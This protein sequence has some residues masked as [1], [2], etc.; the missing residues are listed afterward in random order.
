MIPLLSVAFIPLAIA[1]Q[2]P[3]QPVLTIG[4][5]YDLLE[6]Y[7]LGVATWQ[8][9]TERI[10]DGTDW[11]D[12]I[13]YD[14][15][16][17][18]QVESNSIGSLV[19][20][21]NNCSYSI[22]ENGYV[23]SDKQIIPSVSWMPRIAEV[24]T[25]NYSEMTDLFNQQ[26]SVE[27]RQGEDWVKI[28]SV[29]TQTEDLPPT[30]INHLNGTQSVYPSG[31]TTIATTTQ[32][33]DIRTDNGIKETVSV[34]NGNPEWSNHKFALTQTIHTGDTITLAGNTYDVAAASGTVL[35]RN[36]IENN[37]A[38][39]FE[40]ADSLNYDMDV[41]FEQ[42]NALQVIDDNGTYK[43]ALDYSVNDATPYLSSY[44]VDPTFTS[45][46]STEF[47]TTSSGGGSGS[48]C[49]TATS[50]TGWSTFQV[51]SKASSDSSGY[52][53]N[54]YTEWDVSNIPDSVIIS[55]ATVTL[56]STPESSYT[57]NR[58][59]DVT[60]NFAT[61][62]STIS[63]ASTLESLINTS[64]ELTN[65][66][67]YCTSSG[68]KSLTLTGF[69]LPD[70]QDWYAT[71]Y[72]Y[73]TLTRD[74]NDHQTR[75]SNAILEVVYTLPT[76]PSAPANLSAVSGIPIALDWDASTDLGGAAT[77]DM[78]Y[79]VERSD[80]EFAE[81]PLPINA[82]S[83]TG[84]NMSTNVLLYHLDATTTAQGARDSTYDATNT[85]VTLDTS[86]QKLGSGAYD[87]DSTSGHSDTSTA[88]DWTF[89]HDSTA[90]W[91]FNTWY[92]KPTN[93]GHTNDLTWILE[94]TDGNGSGV[95][96]KFD[97][98]SSSSKDHELQ[99]EV[100]NS[101]NGAVAVFQ[102]GQVYPNDSNWHMLTVTYDYTGSGIEVFVDGTSEGTASVTGTASDDDPGDPLRV[103]TGVGSHERWADWKL[104][105]MAVWK[106]TILTQSQINSLYNSGSGALANTVGTPHAYWNFDSTTNGL[107]NQTYEQ[108]SIIEDTSGANNDSENPQVSS[109][110][111]VSFSTDFS[112]DSGWTQGGSNVAIASGVMSFNNVANG[113]DQH[114]IYDLGSA[115]DDEFTLR[116]VIEI[117]ARNVPAKYLGTL[118]SCSGNS[119]GGC[120]GDK[121][122]VGLWSDHS[123]DDLDLTL[124]DGDNV[125]SLDSIGAYASDPSNHYVALSQNTQYFVQFVRDNQDMTLTVWT[126]SF[127][128]TQVGTFTETLSGTYT[129]IQYLVFGN[130]GSGNS[131]RTISAEIDDVS[132]YDGVTSADNILTDPTFSSG[133]IANQIDSPQI[134]VKSTSLYDGT[135]SHTVGGWTKAIGASQPDYDDFSSSWATTGTKVSSSS[136]VV[137]ATIDGSSL[138][139]YA[140][141]DLGTALNENWVLRY[142]QQATT[143]NLVLQS[144]NAGA[145]Y[146]GLSDSS[147]ISGEQFGNSADSLYQRLRHESGNWYVDG[148]DVRS[149]DGSTTTAGGN[150]GGGVLGTGSQTYYVELISNGADS[151]VKY[152]SD[153]AF[154]TQV[155]NTQTVNI[156]SGVTG[157]QH[158]GVLVFSQ[159][160]SSGSL[161]VE[162]SEFEIYNG[163]TSLLPASTGTMFSFENTAGET[164]SYEVEADKLRVA[165]LSSPTLT[166]DDD[167]TSGWTQ[168]GSTVALHSAGKVQS[169][170]S[171]TNADH[172]IHKAIGTTL[173]NEEWAYQFNFDWV[174]NTS[175][176]LPVGITSTNGNMHTSTHDAVGLF[177]DG[178]N[179]SLWSKDG[180]GSLSYS[181]SYSLS[182]NC[183][184]NNDPPSGTCYYYMT[185]TR[186]SDTTLTLDIR[187]GG[188][189]EGSTLT[190]LSHTIP[191][192][193]QDLQYL[194]HGT[195]TT[196]GGSSGQTWN[197]AN[198]KI[199]DGVT[200]TGDVKTNII[201]AT[202]QTIS[203]STPSHIQ[204]NRGT[205]N[206]W[207]IYLDGT[208]VATAT[209]STSLGTVSSDTYFIGG[210]GSV[211]TGSE[212]N[213]DVNDVAH[214]EGTVGAGYAIGE[215]IQAGNSL[216]GK[217]ITG[218]SF[219]LYKLSTGASNCD[220]ETFTFGIFD[221]SGNLEHSFGNLVCSDITNTGSAH[222]DAVTY[223]KS[224]G[225]HVLVENE[226]VA[227]RTND[228][229][230]S[231]WTV[232]VTQ[233]NSDVYSNGQ[234]AI[235]NSPYTSW[236]T[237][238]NDVGFNA[239]YLGSPTFTN[240]LPSL[241]EFYIFTS[242]KS[243][244]A[245]DIYDRGSNVFAQV[246]ST[247]GS[248]TDHDD[249]SS[250][251]SGT[252]YYHRIIANNGA[253]DSV[254]SAVVQSTAGVPPDAPTSLT[255]AI[256]NPNTAP[257][258]ITLDWNAGASGGTG[259]F[260][261][262]IV[263]RS[264]DSTFTSVSTVGTPTGTTFTDTVPSG[265]GT[266]YYKVSSQSTHGGSANS[267]PVNITT[268]TV[269]DAPTISLAINNPNPSPLVITTTFN[270]PGNVGGS[271]ITGYHLF[272]SGDDVTYTQVA[273]GVSSPYDYTVS[274]SGTHY[275]KA[276]AVNL[277][278]ASVDSAAQSIATPTAPSSPA[279]LTV[280]LP[281][282][283]TAPFTVTLDWTAPASDGGSAV[284]GYKV[285]RDGGLVATLGNVLTVQDTTASN[286]SASF[287]F[288]VKALNNAG[289]STAVA[290]SWTSPAVPSQVQGLSGSM[291]N[292]NV[293]LT[294]SMPS[295]DSAI[296][297]FQVIKG[298]SPL[299]LV[300]SNSTAYTDSNNIIPDQSLTYSVK[301]ISLVGTGSASSNTVVST[302]S[303]AVLDLSATN[304]IGNS[305]VLTWT[306]PIY[307]AG[308][309]QGYMVNYT[310]P[311]GDPN[312]ILVAN[313]GNPTTVL[314]LSS[315]NY[316]ANYTW[317]VGVITPSGT[318]ATGNWY[319]VT[320]GE[321]SSITSY[322][323]T[324]GFDL[325]AT[326]TM[327]LEQIKF[328]RID[329]ADGT[330]TLEVTHPVQYN[331]NCN[332]ASKFAMTN[333]NY[334]NLPTTIIDGNDKK[335]SFIFTGL[336]NEI[337][338]VKCTDTVYS[339]YDS[340]DYI[341]TQ[342]EFPLLQQ[343]QNFSNGTYGTSGMFGVI[344]LISLGAILITMIGF[345][346][347]NHV[348]GGV[349]AVIMF[350]VLGWFEIVQW[351]TV[352][353]GLLATSLML[354]IVTQRK[355]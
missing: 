265:G 344:D 178:G 153:S 137:T 349:F 297:D 284:T 50:I 352:F 107:E 179:L 40:I 208:S 70:G 272:H 132:I 340:A 321:D 302:G 8:S 128:G 17:I 171:P 238:G 308:T 317:S 165:K 82:G 9:H 149:R 151:T 49:P 232:E 102:Q 5:N 311:G 275:F 243:S 332:L 210:Q 13:V 84:V 216:I 195:W 246:G 202:G 309:V 66:N 126:G 294:W 85:G 337:I 122:G 221:T 287:N 313:T 193:V 166:F 191:S 170:N 219:D 249:N 212:G 154:Q 14:R 15:S 338:T 253:F 46:A 245:S 29:K 274:T 224:D 307:S 37:E 189:H 235:L 312:I 45:S 160:I 139:S 20:S 69:S 28:T 351:T 293:A 148:F 291:V 205:S 230:N 157:L 142:K 108:S 73:D 346:R 323:V 30:I 88:S 353:T 63:S 55:S 283:D 281:D 124:V 218:L 146:V 252:D 180:S 326:N 331:L 173:D 247:T 12:F 305:L 96:I 192:S 94:T 78:T 350:G 135:D 196:A 90:K 106:D 52:C 214:F 206:D 155:G 217:T 76:Q 183:G 80:Y 289:E 276:Q 10:F 174:S 240:T 110:P 169:N 273:T 64:T 98:R 199:Y 233:R 285:Y 117:S 62:P 300:G 35:D 301:G 168:V 87:Y 112:S 79:K 304:V 172:R 213:D 86:S 347:V 220:T 330:T 4:Q 251:V 99:L 334:T 296:T 140:T 31:V 129:D 68:S 314:P 328:D 23:S 255:A 177:M 268:P 303:A 41:G 299:A 354:F 93:F 61:Q 188:S 343:I 18:I 329:N 141:F 236:T 176:T 228:N 186:T 231:Q 89:L 48:T 277:I 259:T 56:T 53:S 25:D 116:Y 194:Q 203:S 279:S 175:S 318:N 325:D 310:S 288:E 3:S 42:F 74:S 258:D 101:S 269:P 164:I 27:V 123:A 257:L 280:T 118:Q 32:T 97:D 263:I 264:P 11:K 121:I 266:F 75:M 290:Q 341:L 237:S 306:E 134:T 2:A 241:D 147:D 239:S 65:D 327:E 184:S 267:S 26:C 244:E 113:S 100:I 72:K 207:S 77:G 156:G 51:I 95:G 254:P 162:L 298:G 161:V 256:N 270:P 200:S 7:Q 226:V 336:E 197:L 71:G 130:Q 167:Y 348:V 190:T 209:D 229:P 333:A 38:E 145:I 339:P 250:L 198:S 57:N 120:T 43:V 248:D 67:N 125:S 115:L 24:G 1:Q 16:D 138:D 105:D 320:M 109:P 295:S 111:T 315:L 133:T 201:E 33:L 36:W 22:Y 21:K 47:D 163:I 260:Q 211:S 19:Y 278:G 316:N 81:Q 215:Q 282:V 136:G 342:N 182:G 225:S 150:S 131:V 143:N 104:D 127:G 324:S 223:T 144:G 227:I 271:A 39:I 345:N 92:Q 261:N 54:S 159:S 83:D 34:F 158:L 319:N 152:F 185:L 242:D 58:N 181:S 44:T 91:S 59:C 222:T 286:P 187:N 204:F 322:N 103:G 6:D 234:R 355:K 119:D 292:S 262:Y 114:Q 60:G 335:A